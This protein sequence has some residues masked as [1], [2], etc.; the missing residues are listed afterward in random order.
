MSDN[1]QFSNRLT[2]TSNVPPTVMATV[3]QTPKDNKLGRLNLLILIS[4]FYPVPSDRK[5][6]FDPSHSQFFK[7]V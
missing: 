2:L 7:K 5:F 1:Y 6:N 4:E 3:R